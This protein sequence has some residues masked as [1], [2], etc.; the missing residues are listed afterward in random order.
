MKTAI[1]IS[2]TSTDHDTGIGHPERP[3]RVSV[4]I[5][6]L[7]MQPNL[8]WDVSK[9]FDQNLLNITHSKEYVS[10]VKEKFPAK[11]LHFLDGDTLVSPGSKQAT[12]DFL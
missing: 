8:I 4:V 3:D 5:N 12:L 6:K 9:D 10:N 11:G 2:K 1:I 7:K